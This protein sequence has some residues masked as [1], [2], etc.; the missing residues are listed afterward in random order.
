MRLKFSPWL[1]LIS[2]ALAWR[3]IYAFWTPLVNRYVVPPGDDP[4][5]HIARVADLL[6][7]QWSLFA[8]SYPLGFHI[9]TTIIAKI[10]GWDALT[11]VRLIGPALLII[12]IPVLYFVGKRLFSPATGALAALVWSFLALAPVRAYG[13]GNYANM[14]A[15]S[16]FLPLTLWGLWEWS[17]R[18]RRKTIIFTIANSVVIGLTHHLTFVMG[19]LVAL[20]FVFW[21]TVVLLPSFRKNRR[22]HHPLLIGALSIGILAI[23]LWSFYG[24]L[25]ASFWNTFRSEGSLATWFGAAATPV[26]WAK[27]LEI[28]NPLFL[29]LGLLGAFLLFVSR[30]DRSVKALLLF[31]MAILWIF[32][33]T[34]LFGLPER[35]ARELALPLALTGGYF[36]A[37]FIENARSPLGKTVF[38]ILTLALVALDWRASFSRP[39]ALPDP[40]RPW[41]R[42]HKEEEPALK[43]LKETVQPDTTILANNSNFYLPFLLKEKVIIIRAPDQVAGYLAAE[44]VSVL[45]IGSRPSTT[46]EDLYPFYNSFDQIREAMLAV[47]GK[48]RVFANEW[49]TEVYRLNQN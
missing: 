26:S 23:I 9:I 31:W 2:V 11:A 10:A 28:H 14:L 1:V 30:T 32:S 4:I 36:L 3:A 13:D 8:G 7:G 47:P 21:R 6:A 48:T 44:P 38:L 35:F 16:T 41:V 20:P 34:S 17:R 22:L 37:F 12:P 46:A 42:F 39:F 19:L 24:Q 29:L 40:F 43:A 33:L 18:P 25:L 49:G 27:M 15:G 45:Y 5:F